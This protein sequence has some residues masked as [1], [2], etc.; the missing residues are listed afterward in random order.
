MCMH[1]LMQSLLL[2]PPTPTHIFKKK[3]KTFTLG[4]STHV[5]SSTAQSIPLVSQLCS[6]QVIVC[7]KSPSK[8]HWQCMFLSNWH[9]TRLNRSMEELLL[10]VWKYMSAMVNQHFKILVTG[11]NMFHWSKHKFIPTLTLN[12]AF[13][14][15]STITK[16]LLVLFHKLMIVS[17]R[18]LA[19]GSSRSE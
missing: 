2:L 11:Q 14:P 7:N 12:P 10:L 15:C 19:D 16:Y 3:K 17:R 5:Q 13:V 4:D 8:L 6:T 9:T 1:C 18:V